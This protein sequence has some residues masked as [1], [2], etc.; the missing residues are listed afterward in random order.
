MLAQVSLPRMDRTLI[1]CTGSIDSC[2]IPDA[3]ENILAIA[4]STTDIQV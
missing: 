4:Q 2:I 1:A 3:D